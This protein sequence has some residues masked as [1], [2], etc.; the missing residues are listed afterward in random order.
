MPGFSKIHLRIFCRGA[1]SVELK[2][3]EGAPNE[4][5]TDKLKN[6]TASTD[7]ESASSEEDSELALLST[8]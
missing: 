3:A 8:L 6:E 7:S 5:H 1:E 4:P 2:K